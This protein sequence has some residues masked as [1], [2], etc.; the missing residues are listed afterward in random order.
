MRTCP[1]DQTARYQNC[2]GRRLDGQGNSHIGVWR[3]D[4]PH[5]QGIYD[6]VDGDKYVGDWRAGKRHGQGTM[7]FLDSSSYVGEYR[8]G[9]RHGQGTLTWADVF[10]KFL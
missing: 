7:T 3:N 9:E 2:H 4:R 8:D 1:E 6:G 5:G 10:D